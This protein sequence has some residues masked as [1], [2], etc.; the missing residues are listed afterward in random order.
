MLVRTLPLS[1]R[2]EMGTITEAVLTRGVMLT[3]LPT[4]PVQ[5]ELSHYPRLVHPITLPHTPNLNLAKA[6]PV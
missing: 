5:P 1:I 6:K 3:R 4:I 2:G